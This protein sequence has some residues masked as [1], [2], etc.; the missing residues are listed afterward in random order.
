M[1]WTAPAGVLLLLDAEGNMTEF[2]KDMRV[3]LDFDKLN[4][5]DE[6]TRRGVILT[7]SRVDALTGEEKV[8][9]KWDHERYRQPNPEEVL[10]QKLLLEDVGDVK[11]ASLEAEWNEAESKVKEN[12]R[13][14]AE[15][16]NAASE[17]ASQVGC[18]SLLDMYDAIRPLY[19]AMDNAGW[20]T[21]SFGC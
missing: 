6:T 21:S 1:Q 16:I 3:M 12:L 2:K 20:N 9:V 7:E 11:L 10:T 15:L 8:Y 5:H 4:Q 17:V 18:D 13:E 19:S 14:A